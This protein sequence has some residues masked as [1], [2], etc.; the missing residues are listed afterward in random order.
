[1][2]CLE[3]RIMAAGHG[4]SYS[5][6]FSERIRLHQWHSHRRRPNSNTGECGDLIQSG[7]RG[8]K[9]KSWVLAYPH[10][11]VTLVLSR[12]QAHSTFGM[13]W[14]SIRVLVFV[15]RIWLWLI[16]LSSLR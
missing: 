5:R 6:S 8:I 11:D 4:R 9:S 10:T 16:S 7:L 14:L 12:E 3:H 1:M 2:L 13:G 15:S